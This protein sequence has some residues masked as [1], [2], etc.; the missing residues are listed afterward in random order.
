MELAERLIGKGFE[1]RIYDP[2]FSY[3][4]IMGRNREFILSALP[5]VGSLLVDTLDDALRPCPDHGR[6]P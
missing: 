2:N 1:L 4:D 3:A 5:H 6:R